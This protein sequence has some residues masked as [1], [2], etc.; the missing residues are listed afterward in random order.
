MKANYSDRLVDKRMVLTTLTKVEDTSLSTVYVTNNPEV[1]LVVF[2]NQAALTDYIKQNV[3]GLFGIRLIR[4]GKKYCSYNIPLE[5]GEEVL[6]RTIAE[7]YNILNKDND[8][9]VIMS[10]DEVTGLPII[11]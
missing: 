1:F 10:T 6:A 2:H 8:E 3:D 7:A 11:E 4:E 9:P 5:S